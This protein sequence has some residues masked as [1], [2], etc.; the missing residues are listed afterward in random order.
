METTK[1]IKPI[2]TRYK[3]VEYRSRLEARWAVFFEKMKMTYI[4][5]PFQVDSYLPDF[6]IGIPG[7]VP[8][9]FEIKPLKPNEQ[10]VKH[11]REAQE[12]VQ[13]RLNLYICVGNPTLYQPE[14]IIVGDND[15]EA[16]G[17]DFAVVTN[18]KAHSEAV[19][20]AANFRF[21][22]HAEKMIDLNDVF[23]SCN[24]PR[25]EIKNGKEYIDGRQV[26]R[27]ANFMGS[28]RTRFMFID[29]GNFSD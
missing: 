24:K 8:C 19:D 22:L 11:L 14:G 16:I 1:L 5:E 29:T 9:L 12:L 18:G 20:Y 6:L 28:G 23:R 7:F 21:D 27:I 10:Y 2:P 25:T 17:F 3:G 4:Y 13:S 26:R 15:P